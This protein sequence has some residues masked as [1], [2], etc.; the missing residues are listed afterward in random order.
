MKCSGFFPLGVFIYLFQL[1]YGICVN[2]GYFA[3]INMR[4]HFL[5][6]V[7]AFKFRQN[8]PAILKK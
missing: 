8:N 1:H 6:F 4:I 2:G 5:F 3:L 7:R